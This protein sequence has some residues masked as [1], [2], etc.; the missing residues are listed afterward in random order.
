MHPGGTFHLHLAAYGY[1]D[2][3]RTPAPPLIES[4]GDRVEYRRGPLTEWYSNQSRG[5]EQGFTLRDRPASAGSGPLTLEMELSGDL[6][7]VLAG[8]DVLLERDG[9]EVLRYAGLHA[10]DVAG[11]DLLSRIEVREGHI[12]LLV[13]DEGATYPVTIDPWIQQQQLTASDGAQGD[14]FGISVSV[15]GDTAVVGAPRHAVGGKTEQGA[16]YVFVRN[17]TV[18]TQQQEL[19]ASD[20]VAFDQ[21]G[22]SV[23]VDG[24]TAVI[25]ADQKAVGFNNFQG[26]A[27]VFVRSGT[28]WTQQQKLT[29]SDGTALDHS[30]GRWRL[31]GIRP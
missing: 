6:M 3:L 9:H 10:W 5:L 11:R 4:R 8:R 28:V 20:A 1:G 18:W 12:R 13:Q 2:R 24:N 17:G 26:A 21:F 25:S 19:T 16:A 27:Y 14:F 22:R 29:A 23:A 7:P 15:S 30:V 31:T